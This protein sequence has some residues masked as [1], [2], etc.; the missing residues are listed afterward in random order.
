MMVG[1]LFLI[2]LIP[3]SMVSSLI[4]ER[5]NNRNQATEEISNKWGMNQVIGTPVIS[6]PYRYSEKDEKG[7]AHLLFLPPPGRSVACGC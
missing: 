2:L 6:I 1:I 7:I 5:E 4:T 3:Q